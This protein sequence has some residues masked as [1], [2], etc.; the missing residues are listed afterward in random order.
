MA[1]AGDCLF[2]AIVEGRAVASRVAEDA[3]AIAFL[4]LRQPL[5]GHVL[6]VPRRHAE[7]LYDL[8]ED[9]AAA[10][11]RLA[12]RVARTLRAELQPAGLSLWQSNGR[13][14]GQEV[15]HVHLHLQPRQPADGLVRLYPHGAP[16]PAPRSELDTLA[17]R[18][19]ARFSDGP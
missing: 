14:A 19:R 12:V 8:H 10:V 9:A 7:T 2:C 16:A 11:M 4:D 18:L 15:P 5:P 17:A 3:H 1:V 6:V 13:A